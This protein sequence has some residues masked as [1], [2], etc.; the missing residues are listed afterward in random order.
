MLEGSHIFDGSPND[1]DAACSLSECSKRQYSSYPAMR[2][3]AGPA[4]TLYEVVK[5][6]FA[7]REFDWRSIRT[8]A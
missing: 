3:V 6:S 7:L 2:V 5:D 4:V 8:T 1:R